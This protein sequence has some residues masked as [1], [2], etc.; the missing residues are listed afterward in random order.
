MKV[1]HE[2]QKR[3]DDVKQWIKINPPKHKISVY[4]Y[5][6][7]YKRH[8]KCNEKGYL[9]MQNFIPILEHSGYDIK[10]TSFDMKILRQDKLSKNKQFIRDYLKNAGIEYVY[11]KTFTILQHKKIIRFT[12]FLPKYNIAIKVYKKPNEWLNYFKLEPR[13]SKSFK[14][15]PSRRETIIDKFCKDNNIKL[16]RISYLE[17]TDIKSILDKELAIYF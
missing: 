2:L 15:N 16:I 8:M 3:R 11:H 10:I 13:F 17:F 12:F 5:Y 1:D 7:K 9:L 14:T 6:Q 4:G